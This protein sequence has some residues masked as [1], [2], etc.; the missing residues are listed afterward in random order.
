MT[1]IALKQLSS[2]ELAIASMTTLRASVTPV[3]IVKET[4]VVTLLLGAEMR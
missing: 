4:F 3:A 2:V 1:V